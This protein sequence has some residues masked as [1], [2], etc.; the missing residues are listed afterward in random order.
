M[1][2]KALPAIGIKTV[3]LGEK[4]VEGDENGGIIGKAIHQVSEIETGPG[5]ELSQT[6][7]ALLINV[8]D[9]HI[10]DHRL[11]IAIGMGIEDV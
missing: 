2:C 3:R 9:H 11:G 4:Y 8:H 6:A 5:R 10:L 7:D 1:L